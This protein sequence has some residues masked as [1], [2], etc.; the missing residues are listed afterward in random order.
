MNLCVQADHFTC[1]ENLFPQT[2]SF[3]LGEHYEMIN[4]E[5]TASK[6]I[7]NEAAAVDCRFMMSMF[8]LLTQS[9]V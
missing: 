1:S 4:K 7:N 5:T 2:E 9:S 6:Y 8:S 3:Y